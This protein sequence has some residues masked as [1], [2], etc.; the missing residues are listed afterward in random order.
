ME[1]A[2]T[3]TCREFRKKVGGETDLV[4]VGD[5]LERHEETCPICADW[6]LGMNSLIKALRSVQQES[7]PENFHK[8]LVERLRRRCSEA[9]GPE[10]VI[11]QRRDPARV[12]WKP[13]RILQA[14]AVLAAI[15]VTSLL[16]IGRFDKSAGAGK[17][18]AMLLSIEVS[19][20]NG[21]EPVEIEVELPPGLAVATVE[22]TLSTAR[23]LRWREAGGSTPARRLIGLVAR[24]PG[25]WEVVVRARAGGD[26]SVLKLPLQVSR[27]RIVVKAAV[28]SRTGPRSKKL[29]LKALARADRAPL[30][31]Q[32][33]G[34]LFKGGSV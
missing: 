16:L 29:I 4:P 23:T 5:G 1:N 13:R 11:T 18:G 15:L 10:S 27:E 9:K 8:K 31:P 33:W 12:S 20:T 7:L 19:T 17:V 21:T 3:I 32:G 34:E 24:R 22:P 26:M 25:L 30:Q 28:L 14:A 2:R 6:L